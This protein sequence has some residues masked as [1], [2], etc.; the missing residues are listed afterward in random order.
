MTRDPDAFAHARYTEIVVHYRRFQPFVEAMLYVG[1][2]AEYFRRVKHDIDC[3]HDYRHRM[4]EDQAAGIARQHRWD[5]KEEH[6]VTMPI[7]A[8]TVAP[9]RDG[10]LVFCWSVYHAPRRAH[11]PVRP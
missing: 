6:Q 8:F 3:L 4:S 1:L 11:G 2:V 9:G 5:I 7:L 10:K